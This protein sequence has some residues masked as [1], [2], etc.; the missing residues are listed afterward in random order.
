MLG[1]LQGDVDFLV[2]GERP[3]L[4]PRPGNDAPLELVQE[5]IRL[6]RIVQRYDR[7]LEQARATSLPVLNE[8][9][10]YTLLGASPAAIR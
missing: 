9:R 2:L 5:Y 3:V 8:N 4:P 7:L 6:D 10:L 1:D